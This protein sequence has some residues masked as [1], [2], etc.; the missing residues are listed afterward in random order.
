MILIQ[1]I[2]E[3]EK[4]VLLKFFVCSSIYL[5]K[6]HPIQKGKMV[7]FLIEPDEITMVTVYDAPCHSEDYSAKVETEKENDTKK[8]KIL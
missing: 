1:T 3:V 7:G 4:L 5:L 2:C 6:I 8:V